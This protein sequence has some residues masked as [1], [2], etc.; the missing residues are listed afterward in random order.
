[1]SNY[2]PHRITSGSMQI[3]PEM[4]GASKAT[5][6]EIN[7][8]R[9]PALIQQYELLHVLP[10]YRCADCLTSQRTSIDGGRHLAVS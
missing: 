4:S 6:L 9:R 2:H 8:E 1:M 3:I 7:S 10:S 5:A